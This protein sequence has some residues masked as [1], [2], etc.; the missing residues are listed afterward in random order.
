MPPQTCPAMNEGEWKTRKMRIDTRLRFLNPQW[1]II[2]WHAGLDTSKLTSHAVPE[3]QEIVRRVAGMF[4]LADQLEQRLAQARGQVDKL[5]PSF[6][7]RAFA[8]KLVPPNP[9]DEPAEKLLQKVKKQ[10]E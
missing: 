3:Q 7:A 8:G 2:P 4:A 6:L 5:T 9:T 10:K 1:Q